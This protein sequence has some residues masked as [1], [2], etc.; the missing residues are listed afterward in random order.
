VLSGKRTQTPSSS[1]GP[2]SCLEMQQRLNEKPRRVVKIAMVDVRAHVKR[3][4]SR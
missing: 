1:P 2:L 3:L 4:V